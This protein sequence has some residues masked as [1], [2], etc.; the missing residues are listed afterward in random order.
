MPPK[1]KAKGKAKAKAKAK[2]GA[3][4]AAKAGAKAKAKGKAEPKRAAST[5][6]G[7][8]AAVAR[9]AAAPPPP[10]KRKASSSSL[11]E[12]APKGGR[13]EGGVAA[14]K[15]APVSRP[16]GSNGGG[17]RRVDSRCPQQG[18]KVVEDYTAK[19]NQTN[20]GQNNNKFYIIQALEGGGKYYAWNRWGR[21][22]DDGKNQLIPCET[23]NQ[24]I[25]LFCGKFHDKTGN[26]WRLRDSFVKKPGKYQLVD[27]DETG[28]DGGADQA[29]GKL[30]QAQIEKGQ[31]VLA[32]L[33]G[34]LGRSNSTQVTEL[35]SEFYSLIPHNFGW[36]K[37]VAITTMDMLHEKEELLK[38]FLRMGF[39][40]VEADT[41]VSPISGVMDLPLPKSLEEAAN[42]ICGK[43]SISSSNKK[44]SELA[45][46]QAGS[47]KAKMADALYAAIMLYTSNAIYADLNR[48]LRD[49]NRA[50]ITKYFKYL[51]LLI[52]AMQSLPQKKRTLWRGISVDLSSD[53]QYSVGKTVT[54]WG[55]SS[56]TSDEK[57]ARGFAKGCGGGCTIVTINSQTA[58][59]ISSISFYSHEKESLLRPGTQL[60]VK[61][62]TKKGPITEVH[63]D[64]VG[65]A[66]G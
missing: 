52:E 9:G 50:K 63:V 31:K 65:V 25:N 34:A 59:D 62:R 66:I 18:L 49:K 19:L 22:G 6:R 41:G 46:V 21:V 43:S 1:A 23:K 17:E 30:T 54:W 12:P 28:G 51:R 2:V 32:N 38:F 3:K 24:A 20:V 4:A 45:K 61:S 33:Q 60:K 16:S 37:P 14:P 15:A 56:C 27:T 11:P 35:S 47:P 55:V 5:A 36:K 57:V 7:G 29:L 58:C 26:T 39:E 48:C 10:T 8:A 64:E 42:G 13:G 53:P 44:G 40:E